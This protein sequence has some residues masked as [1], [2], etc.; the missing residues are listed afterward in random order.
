MISN[1]ANNG[2]SDTEW[3]NEIF[4]IDGSDPDASYTGCFPYD[5]IRK[6]PP[7]DST[8]GNGEFYFYGD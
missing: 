7:K 3:L 6:Y 2:S 8:L 1:Y 4:N 5:H